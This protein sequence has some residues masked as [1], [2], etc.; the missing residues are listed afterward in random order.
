MSKLEDRYGED[1]DD[2]RNRLDNDPT[3]QQAQA[4]LDDL[5]AACNS[6]GKLDTND[7]TYM[8]DR[9]CKACL[10][11]II[12]I[13]HIDTKKHDARILLGAM[14]IIKSDLIPLISQ[15]CDYNDGDQDLFKLIIRLCTNLTSSALLLFEDQEVPT[16]TESVKTYNKL[17]HGLHSY[18]EAFAEDPKI[19]FNLNTH[20]RHTEEEIPFERLLILI[21]N[22]LHIPVDSTADLGI[23]SGM[24]AHELSLLRMNQSGIFGTL[25]QVASETQRGM[26][27]CFHIIEIVY[28]MLRDQ[29][30]ITVSQAKSSQNKR[31]LEDDDHDK[32]RL[33]ELSARHKREKEM[34]Q[35]NSLRPR[36][37][38]STF[39]IRNMSSLGN[40]PIVMRSIPKTRE[41]V[42]F[43][44]YKTELRKAKNK[45]PLSSESNSAVISDRNTKTSKITYSLKVFSKMFV[46]KAY[47]NYMQQIKHNLIQKKAAENDESYYLWAIQYFTCFNRHLYLNMDNISETL[48]TSTLH[49]I[50][51]LIT[52][53]QDKLKLEK[54]RNHIEKVSKRLHLAIRAYRE[55]LYLIQSIKPD[56]DF[57]KVIET[58]KK[59]IFTEVEYNSLLLTMFQTY[60]SSKHCPEY[61][62]D[63][64]KAN[65]VFLELLEEYSKTH[66]PVEFEP[67]SDSDEEQ[68]L[69]E[70]AQALGRQS[71]NANVEE[72]YPKDNI[73]DKEGELP[74]IVADG[75]EL[76][77]RLDDSESEAGDDLPSTKAHDGRPQME[78]DGEHS[79]MDIGEKGQQDSD[80]GKVTKTK[81]QDDQIE[82]IID[83][84]AK[85]KTK[86]KKRKKKKQDFKTVHF[87]SRYC[88]PEVIKSYLD[89]LYD[90]K[91]NDTAINL[92]IIKFLERVVY[93]CKCEVMLMQASL[94]KCLLEI[95]DYHSSLP[96]HDRFV[97]LTKH[98]MK[99][100]GEM[101]HKKRWMIQELLFWKTHNDVIE[102]EN[103]VDP[104]PAPVAPSPR[105]EEENIYSPTCEDAEYIDNDEN[106]LPPPVDSIDDLMA[107]L[108]SESSFN[109]DDEDEDDNN[110][111]V[112]NKPIEA[113]AVEA[114]DAV[115][116]ENDAKLDPPKESAAAAPND[117]GIDNKEE[118]DDDDEILTSLPHKAT[119]RRN[120]LES[121]DGSSDS[122]VSPRIPSS[123]SSSPLPVGFPSDSDDLSS[124]PSPVPT[125]NSGSEV[126]EPHLSDLPDA[127]DDSD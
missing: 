76:L 21:R 100:F 44:A 73:D 32:K 87:M 103:A 119:N 107:E 53:Y 28:L 96:G 27:F 98:L 12:R 99:T 47:A 101:I 40:N 50:Q 78:A 91:N 127:S 125:P 95:N 17:M 48:S 120:I 92:N 84:H 46:E 20:L 123:G 113:A 51:I 60:D 3:P 90:F 126:G 88:T 10:K 82:E 36:F 106:E 97:A 19:W 86:R 79:P 94:L 62:K 55:I 64:I 117:N 116:K 58:I 54:K 35:K 93:D 112:A 38:N 16:E 4:L 23:K 65:H 29:N 66:G 45:K 41:D 124:P 67:P 9:D 69:Q 14:N 33:A 25:I 7:G 18:K 80:D 26:E 31:R 39:A 37:K 1:D 110:D 70:D 43:D 49:F 63:L 5:T 121:D 61:M 89:S 115:V 22:I 42:S 68:T 109:S 52:T 118:D 111:E 74:P 85:K 34:Q 102:I 59:N 8:K 11:E 122:D 56:S 77:R 114:T 72:E 105:P 81:P 6:L 24:D 2:G 75:D 13:L 30:P 104:P 15:Y 57:W 71:P 108:G 83:R